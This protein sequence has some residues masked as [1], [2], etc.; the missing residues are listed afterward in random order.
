LIY[1]QNKVSSNVT[2]ATQN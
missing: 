2:N 1:C